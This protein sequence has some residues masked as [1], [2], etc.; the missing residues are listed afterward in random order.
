M[1][2]SMLNYLLIWHSNCMENPGFDNFEDASEFNEAP[3]F[4]MDQKVRQAGVLAVGMS[5]FHLPVFILLSQL[6]E[7][8]LV[9]CKKLQ[10][11][12]HLPPNSLYLNI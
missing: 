6:K 7:L 1:C 10:R 5:L 12:F 2:P 9:H 11:L 4:L 8:E 3:E